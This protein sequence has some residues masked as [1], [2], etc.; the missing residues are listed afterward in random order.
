MAN[1][2]LSAAKKAK[3]DE[4]Y[5]Q[6]FDIENE[7][8]H[9][10][11][12]FEGKVVYLNC[13]DPEWSNF[14]KF[15]ELNFVEYKLKRLVSTH[16]E[17]DKPSYMLEIIG[18]QN[19]DGKIDANDI[20]KTP[21]Q[22]NGDFRSPESIELLKQCDVVVTNPPF[23]LFRE[24][25][26]QL[27]EYQKYFLILGNNN[28]VTYKEIFP[29]IKDN[30]MWLGYSSNKTIEFEVPEGYKYSREENGKKYGK[31]PA[32]TWYTNIPTTKRSEKLILGKRYKPE[33][34][35]KYDNYDAIEVSKVVDIPVDYEGVM[36]V[37]ITFLDKYCPEQFEIVGNEYS[38]NIDKGR[39][40]VNGNRMYSRILIKKKDN[41]N[42]EKTD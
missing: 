18:D 41:E 6:L 1:K 16:Y 25:V 8:K 39:V 27:I 23:S 29:L 19:N 13:D 36:G 14:W 2:N 15:F 3:N 21:L 4:F 11:S 17:V 24:Y 22:Q 7:V 34:Y 40:Y 38:E 35:P 37:P 20:I 5:T 32:I 42:R 12:F 28:A 30:K 31:V 26:A 33:D 9:Y 10:K